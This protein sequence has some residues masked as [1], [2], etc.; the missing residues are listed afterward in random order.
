M[1]THVAS[2][3]GMGHQG[4]A[5]ENWGQMRRRFQFIFR[6]KGEQRQEGPC[7]PAS[8]CAWQAG[9]GVGSQTQA[10][11]KISAPQP[12]ANPAYVCPAP[13]DPFSSQAKL[14]QNS[15]TVI[16][17][18]AFNSYFLKYHKGNVLEPR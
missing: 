3:E 12:L 1:G 18:S 9:V 15:K 2:S 14:S 7:L 16:N 6:N 13:W 8:P 4:Q 10:R 17:S 11:D 5:G